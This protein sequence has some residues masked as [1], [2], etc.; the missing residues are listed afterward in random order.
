MELIQFLTFH[1]CLTISGDPNYINPLGVSRSPVLAY[2]TCIIIQ[3]NN[4]NVILRAEI[5]DGQYVFDIPTVAC[6]I[7]IQ[8]SAVSNQLQ[9]LKLKGEI[10]YELK[11]PAY[12]YMIIN[13]PKD[14]CSLAADLA[15]WCAK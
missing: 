13:F 11:D 3:T 5:K 12:C 2:E 10:T 15:K 7:G 4:G 9:I 6:S 14:I 1:C 8:T